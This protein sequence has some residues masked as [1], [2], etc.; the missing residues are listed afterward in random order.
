MERRKLRCIQDFNSHGGGIV[1][2]ARI[3]SSQFLL[4][5]VNLLR[6]AVSRYLP[7]E[8]PFFFGRSKRSCT[9]AKPLTYLASVDI[10]VMHAVA[11][12]EDHS[13]S[14]KA[15]QAFWQGLQLKVGDLA[16]PWRFFALF[17][18]RGPTLV[19]GSA[20]LKISFTYRAQSAQHR[21]IAFAS[22][23]SSTKWLLPCSGC[24][25]TL[26]CYPL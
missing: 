14:K 6:L 26:D 21:L 3:L 2:A 9:A 13:K 24:T 1:E 16:E 20:I 8:V 25:E 22:H 12:C 7:D 11:S 18:P 19:G 4:S 23:N 10:A 5:R 15:D 17:T